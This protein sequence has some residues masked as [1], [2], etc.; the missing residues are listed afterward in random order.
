MSGRGG[1][2][3]NEAVWRIEERKDGPGG[4]PVYDVY[5]ETQRV[6]WGLKDRASAVR[7]ISRLDGAA[8]PEARSAAGKIATRVWWD[9]HG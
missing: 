6:V 4:A 9:E 2:S 5:R 1:A 3:S 8:P 7:W